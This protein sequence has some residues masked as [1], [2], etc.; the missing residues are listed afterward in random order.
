MTGVKSGVRFLT[1]VPRSCWRQ[2]SLYSE[3]GYEGLNRP[4]ACHDSGGLI[5]WFLLE[6]ISNLGS[7]DFWS[8]DRFLISHN[9]VGQE[10]YQGFTGQFS[11]WAEVTLSDTHLVARLSL[12]L[13]RLQSRVW[14]PAGRGCRPGSAA[15]S[16]LSTLG[17]SLWTLRLGSHSWHGSLVFVRPVQ[18]LLVLFLFF[19]KSFIEYTWFTVL[20]W[21]LL[22]SKVTQLYIYAFFFILFFHCGLSQ[23]VEYISSLCYTVWPCC[24]SILYII[25]CLY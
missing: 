13:G 15:S 18:K 14:C 17:A 9:F 23:N 25:A 22:Y 12:C 10:F 6:Q 8:G 20:C 21:I 16:S 7:W 11:L 3:K 24:L 5:I 19:F 2:D 4:I 1:W